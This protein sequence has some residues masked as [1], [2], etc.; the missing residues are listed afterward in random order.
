MNI[1]G[2]LIR[3]AVGLTALLGLSA[4][5]F[6]TQAA[7]VDRAVDACVSAFVDRYLLD[8]TVTIHKLLPSPG[9]LDAL[10]RKDNYTIVLDARSK[11]SGEQLA[12]A[13]CVASRRG[14]VIVLDS[15]VTVDSVA[16]A[17]FRATLLR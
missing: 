3:K 5:P 7:G 17:D 2:S 11:R 13:T 15:S 10:T 6:T 4:T 8:R 14:D 12:Q 1:R 9:P 16:K